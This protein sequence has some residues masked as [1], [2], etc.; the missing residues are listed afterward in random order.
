MAASAGGFLVSAVVQAAVQEACKS[1]RA[2]RNVVFTEVLVIE[3][4][5][6]WRVDAKLWPPLDRDAPAADRARA[7]ATELVE[8]L[9]ERRVD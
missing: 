2:E 6:G 8:H 5:K 9:A 4:E 3:S 1:Y 7:M